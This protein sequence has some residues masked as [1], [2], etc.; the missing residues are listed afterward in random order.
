[1]PPSI[2]PHA[3]GHIIEQIRMVQKILDNGYEY[4]SEGSVY[5]DVEKYN[6]SHHYGKLSG[7]NIEDM[8]SATRSLEGQDAPWSGGFPGWHIECTA[9]GTRY[10]GEEFD[11]HGGGMDLLF[12]H[13]ECE[14]AQS[15][16]ALNKESV[17]YWMHNNMITINGQKMGKSLGNFITLE[18]FF[19][20]EHESLTQAYSPMTIRFFILS[21]HYR[22]TV[23][24]SDDALKA[25]EK[26]L[27]KL[28]TAIADL[29]RVPVS[30]GCDADTETFVKTLRQRCYDAMNDDFQT[31]LVIS[32]LF[33]ACR[34]VNTLLDHKATICADCLQELSSTMRMFAFELLGLRDER[35]S[36]NGAF[37]KAFDKVM[38]L[39]LDWRSQAKSAKDWTTSDRIRDA[40]A[41]AGIE[42]KDTK[43]GVT[44]KLTK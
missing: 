43:D 29:G 30:A 9:M 27:E 25:S 3:S 21:A 4:V 39:V 23:D 36:N 16:A 15:V 14:I 28:T 18:Q 42:V 37:E 11:I 38:D 1:L 13:H 35:S 32:Y 31:Q 7:R 12:P 6:K 17:R 22:S 2:E 44:W 40:L 10:L 34:V 33:E 8:L 24:F 26:G 41:D 20:G 5:F 19:T